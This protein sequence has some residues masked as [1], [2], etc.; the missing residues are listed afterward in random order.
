MKFYEITGNAEYGEQPAKDSRTGERVTLTDKRAALMSGDYISVY[1]CEVVP[2]E[3]NG[4]P[5]ET[6]FQFLVM[7]GSGSLSVY[8]CDFETGA[9][10][11][12]QNLR[13][14]LRGD[15]NCAELDEILSRLQNEY[16]G[17]ADTSKL[18]LN[19]A[20]LKQRFRAQPDNE[21]YTAQNGRRCLRTVGNYAWFALLCEQAGIEP[22]WIESGLYATDDGD[23][24]TLSY[25]EH[26]ITLAFNA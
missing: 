25:C 2:N 23:G 3:D 24:F 6:A 21:E 20:D 22:R 18:K 19:L 10:I 13:P 5:T 9:Q 15:M 14:L 12:E 8:V 1:R 11:I 26:D 4:T 16:S 17:N 7:N